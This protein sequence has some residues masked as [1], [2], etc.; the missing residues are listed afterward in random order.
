MAASL[1]LQFASDLGFTQAVLEGDSQV[2]MTVL[3]NDSTFLSSNGLLIDDVRFGARIFTQL[4]NSH[5][6][7]EGN[8]IA[9]NLAQ[10]FKF[11]SVDRGCS[12]TFSFCFPS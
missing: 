10:Y 2:L 7:K 11:C 4:C 6:K 3:I 1:A 8:K 5:V 12:I 9:H